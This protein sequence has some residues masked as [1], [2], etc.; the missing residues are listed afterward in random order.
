MAKKFKKFFEVNHAFSDT[1]AM[2]V[3]F[4]EIV[5]DVLFFVIITRTKFFK[6]RLDSIR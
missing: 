4:V 1:Y 5:I 6:K 2:I 3:D